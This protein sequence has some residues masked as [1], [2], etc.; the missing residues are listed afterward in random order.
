MPVETTQ[1]GNYL[2]KFTQFAKHTTSETPSWLRELREFAFARFCSAGFPTTRD[3]DWRFTNVAELARMPF[4]LA[5]KSAAQ[6]MVSDLEPW[7]MRSAAAR[8]VFVDGHF[9]PGLSTR[10]A[11][12]D[13]VTVNSL[14]EEIT[15]GSRAV[16][17]HLGRYL[18]I[19]RDSFCAL[20]TAFT[21]DGAF[22]H[23]DRGAVVTNP[24]HLLFISM[25]SSTPAMTHPRNLIVIED[26]GQASI[27]EEY[28]SFGAETP[29][30]SDAVT[31]LVSGR[32]RRR[33]TYF[34]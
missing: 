11:L 10:D 16:A 17:D 15:N 25:S 24:I 19:E 14:R 30:F 18:D 20:N 33:R 27:V 5:R 9:A 23:V 31:E 21:Y 6:L 32:Q 1:L 22:V 12:P 8:M 34:N 28:V 26:E 2:E 29:A 7:R 4:Q 13:R 3:E